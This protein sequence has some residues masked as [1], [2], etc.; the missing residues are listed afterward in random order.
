MK[1]LNFNRI[2][3]IIFLLCCICFLTSQSQ[4]K[5]SIADALKLQIKQAN[6]DT[7]KI[8]LKLDLAGRMALFNL[9]TAVVIVKDVEKL[10]KSIDEN[11]AFFKKTKSTVLKSL[12]NAETT[13]ENWANALEYHLKAIDYN[14]KIKDS[15]GLGASY[16][17]LGTIYLKIKDLE[18]GEKYIRQALKIQE[19]HSKPK[20]FANTYKKLGRVFFMKRELDSAVIMYEKAKTIDTTKSNILS[21]ESSIASIYKM[22]KKYDKALEI[23]KKILK[24]ADPKNHASMGFY[25]GNLASTYG[26]LY[27]WENA[28]KAVDSCIYFNTSIGRKRQLE[29]AY[30][31][32]S[33]YLRNL[34]DY[35]A[36]YKAQAMY[37]VY[38]DSVNNVE[39]HKRITKLDLNYKFEKERAITDL[40]LKNEASKKQLYFALL[41]ITAISGLILFYFIRKSSKQKLVLAAN[42]IEL[43][44][45]E[46]LKADLALANRENELKKIA[47]ENSITEELLNK[48]LDDIKEII[49]YDNEQERKLALKSLS[50]DLLSEKFNQKSSTSLQSY[51]NDVSLDFK[52]LLDTHFK[53]LNPKEK[54]LLC[55]MKLGLNSTEISKLQNNT[56]AAVKSLRYRVRKKLG[57]DSKQDII[58][59]IDTKNL[60]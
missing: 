38:S 37:K 14:I 52:V 41:L 44:K 54:E 28:L 8:N 5:D 45:V 60:A 53:A 21:A 57:L 23:N 39:E 46:K 58:A 27:D 1:V 9:D 43:K 34:N 17:G 4:Q 51:L 12:A 40:E 49:T 50:A 16:S 24:L 56:I 35:K 36:A 3:K 6:S 55:L 47:I 19:Y 13:K 18:N 59:Y 22:H 2:K 7:L 30:K 33:E 32:K 25:Y 20:D 15:T 31:F 10:I 29:L 11:S 42:E 48:T 26:L